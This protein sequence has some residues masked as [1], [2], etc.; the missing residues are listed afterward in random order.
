MHQRRFPGKN[1]VSS[2]SRPPARSGETCAQPPV[3]KRHGKEPP[4][5]VRT[6]RRKKRGIESAGLYSPSCIMS[7]WSV[8]RRDVHCIQSLASQVAVAR[9]KSNS[10]A[11]LA[12]SGVELQITAIAMPLHA[13]RFLSERAR[14]QRCSMHLSNTINAGQAGPAKKHHLW[15]GGHRDPERWTSCARPAR[16]SAVDTAACQG[17]QL[18]P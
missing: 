17:R 8:V 6:D 11:R 10:C 18:A 13:G 1:S 15:S 14:G 5:L 9:I 4:A 12:S 16:A 7:P 2:S 3:P